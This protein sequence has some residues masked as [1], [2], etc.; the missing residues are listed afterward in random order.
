LRTCRNC[1]KLAHSPASNFVF[2]TTSLAPV[3]PAADALT[4]R[5]AWPMS[6]PTDASLD[7]ADFQ[8]FRSDAHR[9]L[10]ACLDHLADARN[11]PWRPVD[12]AAPLR[13]PHG[14]RRTHEA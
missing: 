12:A 13:R 3:S 14:C 5:M 2:A 9:L 6:N 8:A 11:Q 4:P 1:S 10:D 7:P